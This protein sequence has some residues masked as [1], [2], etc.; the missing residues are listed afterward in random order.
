MNMYLFKTKES[1]NCNKDKIDIFAVFKIPWYTLLYSFC[2][3]D[4]NRLFDWACI[5]VM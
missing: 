5:E 3:V 4:L 1:K 2:E